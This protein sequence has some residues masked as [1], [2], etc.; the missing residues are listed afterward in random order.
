MGHAVGGTLSVTGEPLA[1]RA[2][3]EHRFPAAAIEGARRV[4]AL[5]QAT[6]QIVQ[7]LEARVLEE[8]WSVRRLV[9][10]EAWPAFVERHMPVG[11]DQADLMA[12]TWGA[13]R[14][15]RELREMA[16][17]EPSEALDLIRQ[18]VDAGVPVEDETDERLIEIMAQ[19]PRLRQRT[20][21][22]LIEAAPAAGGGAEDA[23]AAEASAT[24]RRL[25][26][27]LRGLRDVA[28]AAAELR[29]DAEVLLATAPPRHVRRDV[30]QWADA[31]AAAIDR[32]SELAM[33]GAGESP[34][35]RET[36]R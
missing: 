15:R 11:L 7:I 16:Q 12:R 27:L 33:V 34:A 21:R 9:A 29:M 13:A 5:L 32:I 6:R 31:T 25:G 8:T 23:P 28:G 14:G 10:D 36:P 2:A 20:I 18:C 26:P 1:P 35:I 22:R 3:D 19:P 30:T 4:T 17:S 24:E